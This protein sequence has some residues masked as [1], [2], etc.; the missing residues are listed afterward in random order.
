MSETGAA[1]DPAVY[2]LKANA[3]VGT[4]TYRLT[5]EALTWEEDGKPLDGVF[6]DEIAEVRLAFAPT[7]V[8]PNRY[9]AQIVFRKGGMVELFNLE[10]VGFAS[11]AAHDAGYAAFLTELHRRLAAHG[12]NVVYRRGN[13]LTG[14]ILN[15]GLTIFI[16]VAIAFAVLFL[17]N[18]GGPGIAIVKL[19]I[20]LFFVPLLI[21][22]IRRARPGTYDPLALPADV[23]PETAAAESA[24]EKPT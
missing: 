13:T 5:D 11:F 21:R 16:F 10:Y 17:I 15:V 24:E 19:V 3:F 7:R 9:R 23:L 2:R 14:Y 22:Y 1:I 8:A 18:V 12:K 6:Y 4:R 20:I